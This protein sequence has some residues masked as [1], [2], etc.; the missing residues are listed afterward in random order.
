M[1]HIGSNEWLQQH[2]LALAGAG[3]EALFSDLLTRL[4]E[5]H[6][7][8]HTRMHIADLLQLAADHQHLFH[9]PEQVRWAIWYHDAVYNPKSS[10][11]EQDSALLARQQ[12]ER[13]GL[14]P[15]LIQ[16][17]EALILA[18]QRHEV[19]VHWQGDDCALFLDLDLSILAASRER[20]ER[21]A[22]EIRSEF[23]MYP[24]LLYRPGRRKVLQHFL[25][26]PHIYLTAHFRSLWEEPARANLQWEMSQL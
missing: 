1:P 6:R 26:K 8:Y 5:P 25:Q 21:Y 12:L 3:H 16:A 22:R 20:Y 9:S 10:T 13:M 17:V 24:N 4:D 11:N 23:S 19:P 7:H 15:D 2:W 18:T 14:N